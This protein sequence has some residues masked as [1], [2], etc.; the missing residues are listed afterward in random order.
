MLSQPG[1][2]PLEEKS[3]D[4]LSTSI[5]QLLV[6]QRKPPL[7]APSNSTMSVVSQLQLSSL[8]TFPSLSLKTPFGRNS[9]NSVKSL[10]S[11]YQRIWNLVDQRDSDTL[12]TT[13]SMML[14]R[15]SKP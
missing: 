4:V 12:N 2:E 6:L 13:A 14:R 3:M 15:P 8:E 7:D 1:R 10:Q 9:E 5:S 11:D